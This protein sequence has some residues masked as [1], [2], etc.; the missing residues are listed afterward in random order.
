MSFLTPSTSD[1]TLFYRHILRAAS[2]LRGPA[3]KLFVEAKTAV[4]AFPSLSPI[5]SNFI[6][7]VMVVEEWQLKQVQNFPSEMHVG[8][9]L[10]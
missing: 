9:P 5:A 4:E 1:E 10:K 2:S 8:L 3:E 6:S 7:D